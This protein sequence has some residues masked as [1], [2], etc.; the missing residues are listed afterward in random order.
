[1][2]SE[3]ERERKRERLRMINDLSDRS[4]PHVSCRFVLFIKSSTED[5]ITSGNLS[6]KEIKCVSYYHNSRSWCFAVDW[7]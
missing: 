2:V 7:M 3:R 5:A 4:L 1:M 6:V